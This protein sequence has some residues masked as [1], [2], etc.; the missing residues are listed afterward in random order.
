MW[1]SVRLGYVGVNTRSFFQNSTIPDYGGSAPVHTLINIPAALVSLV[2]TISCVAK[3]IFQIGV[4][5]I[6]EVAAL[7]G[8]KKAHTWSQSI[9]LLL[10]TRK[11]GL[12]ALGL[13][14]NVLGVVPLVF[15]MNHFIYL[16]VLK[17]F[18]KSEFE[19]LVDKKITSMIATHSP[20]KEEFELSTKDVKEISIQLLTEG[21]SVVLCYSG[22]VGE[23][24]QVV[25]K[26]HGYTVI[27]QHLEQNNSSQASTEDKFSYKDVE[28]KMACTK[29]ELRRR[30]K[31]A[32]SDVDDFMNGKNSPT[33]IDGKST[34]KWKLSPNV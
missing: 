34:Y 32:C 25:A 3:L 6:L 1:A 10:T 12:F 23:A 20:Q 27:E 22:F 26:K 15:G 2:G 9:D 17:S 19:N 29:E 7:F 24:I 28:I 21:A 33:E 30:S 18:G 31:R 4:K 11:T 13:F 14:L 5:P 16:E 8:S